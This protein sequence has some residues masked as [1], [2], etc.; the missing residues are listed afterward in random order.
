MKDLILVAVMCL[1][2]GCAANINANLKQHSNSQQGAMPQSILLDIS[3]S[4][5]VSQSKD[6]TNS[7]N[8]L[9]QLITQEYKGKV[10]ADTTLDHQADVA[11]DITIQH[12]R[13]VSGL[14]RFLTG[15][16][17]GDAELKLSIRIVDLET[18][19]NPS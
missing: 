14:G 10:F 12:Y 11:V 7:I 1:L 4:N 5:M 19:T 17:V 16:M 18:N 2:V 9:K 6:L 3:S 13:H 8:A 15:I